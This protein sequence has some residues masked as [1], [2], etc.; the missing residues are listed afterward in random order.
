M[1]RNKKAFDGVVGS[2]LRGRTNH[3]TRDSAIDAAKQTRDPLPSKHLPVARYP[4]PPSLSEETERAT[5][6]PLN[7]E[8]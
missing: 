1:G 2:K 6:K 8:P 3:D 4:P 7:P 5:S